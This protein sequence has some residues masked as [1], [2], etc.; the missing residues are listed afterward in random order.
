MLV[1]VVM[2][3]LPVNC[4]IIYISKIVGQP[5]K[6]VYSQEGNEGMPQADLSEVQERT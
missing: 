6:I 3:F 2:K 4:T 1:L 5:T